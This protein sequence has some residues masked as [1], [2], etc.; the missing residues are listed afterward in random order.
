MKQGDLAYAILFCVA[1]MV[2]FIETFKDFDSGG[3]EMITDKGYADDIAIV[4]DTA[5]K[6]DQVLRGHSNNT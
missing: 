2:I 6:M 5:E 4:T 3:G 1:L